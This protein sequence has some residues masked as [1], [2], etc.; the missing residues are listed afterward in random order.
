MAAESRRVVIRKRA[1]AVAS[2]EEAS[3]ATPMHAWSVS[4]PVLLGRGQCAYQLTC[5]FC[6][7]KRSFMASSSSSLGAVA[8]MASKNMAGPCPDRGGS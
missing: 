2:A 7:E 8:A 1:L 3:P 5:L 6:G 4:A